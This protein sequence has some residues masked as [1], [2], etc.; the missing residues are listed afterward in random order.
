MFSLLYS[1]KW[2]EKAFNTPPGPVSEATS[3]PAGA[4]L[5]NTHSVL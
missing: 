1:Q 3:L 2:T 5:T 4:E